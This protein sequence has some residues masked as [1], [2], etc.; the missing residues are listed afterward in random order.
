MVTLKQH[1]DQKLAD[2]ESERE[3]IMKEKMALS[4]VLLAEWRV[5]LSCCFRKASSQMCCMDVTF[6]PGSYLVCI[7]LLRVVRT[8]ILS[9]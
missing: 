9:V 7:P 8:T 6:K 2:M 4:E 3:A 1:Y 5:E